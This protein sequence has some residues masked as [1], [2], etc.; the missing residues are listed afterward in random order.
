M[1]KHLAVNPDTYVLTFTTTNNMRFQLIKNSVKNIPDSKK[2]IVFNNGKDNLFVDKDYYEEAIDSGLDFLRQNNSEEEVEWLNKSGVLV[3][4]GYYQVGFAT[5]IKKDEK[6]ISEEIDSYNEKIFGALGVDIYSSYNYLANAYNICLY[7]EYYDK[8][9]LDFN[10]FV[11]ENGL[12]PYEK[13]EVVSRY[14]G[15]ERREYPIQKL[16][17]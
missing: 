3:P 13:I 1:I 11:S 2:K 5:P 14:G 6:K 9:V 8:L 7:G 12:G 17:K 10:E 15:L 4:C 16:R